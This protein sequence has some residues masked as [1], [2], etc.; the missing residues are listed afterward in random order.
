MSILE[1]LTLVLADPLLGTEYV[2]PNFWF[3]VVTA[4]DILRKEGV[5]VGK[6]DFLG[7][8]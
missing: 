7:S 8:V 4:Y 1:L 5:P 3:H 6:M 2:L